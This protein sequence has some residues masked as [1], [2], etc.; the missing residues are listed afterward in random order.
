LFHP[1]VENAHGGKFFKLIQSTHLQDFALPAPG[2]GQRQT[3]FPGSFIIADGQGQP[4][5]AAFEAL[6]VEQPE[7]TFQRGARRFVF[8]TADKV[9]GAVHAADCIG[10]GW[11]STVYPA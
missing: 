5:R 1:V 8:L 2:A 3:M 10:A 9:S 4:I 6:H 7:G 11:T